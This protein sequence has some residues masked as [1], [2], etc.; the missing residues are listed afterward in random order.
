MEVV[1]VEDSEAAAVNGRFVLLRVRAAGT[2]GSPFL[3][4]CSGVRVSNWLQG[5]TSCIP[6]LCHEAWWF[7]I[8]SCIFSS[9]AYNHLTLP[10]WWK[11]HAGKTIKDVPGWN[12]R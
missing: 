5:V 12:T 6:I 8:H 11:A 4:C 10:E 2:S 7:T 9:Y 1:G 3:L